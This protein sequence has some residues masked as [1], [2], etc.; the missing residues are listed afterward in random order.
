[1]PRRDNN[2][3]HIDNMGHFITSSADAIDCVQI[4]AKF[5]IPTV[6]LGNPASSKNKK[7]FLVK[8]EVHLEFDHLDLAC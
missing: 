2:Y 1:M 4:L 6:L 8:R 5:L 3:G 7:F